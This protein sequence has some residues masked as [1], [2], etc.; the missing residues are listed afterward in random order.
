MMAAGVGMHVDGDDVAVSLA[1][2]MEG[3]KAGDRAARRGVGWPLLR[4]W[5]AAAAAFGPT[6][7]GSPLAPACMPRLQR[8]GVSLGG[9]HS[10][11]CLRGVPLGNNGEGPALLDEAGKF[12]TAVGD[13]GIKAETIQ[14]ETATRSRA[15]HSRAG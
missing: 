6:S 11:A 15:S 14:F 5:L 8:L 4:T 9:I 1:L 10:A 2:E 13:A 3:D 7:T 12:G